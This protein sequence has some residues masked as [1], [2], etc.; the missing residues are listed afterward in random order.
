MADV[1]PACREVGSNKVYAQ[2]RR[3]SASSVIV[4]VEPFV[5]L[6]LALNFLCFGFGACATHIQGASVLRTD[7]TQRKHPFQVFAAAC[8]A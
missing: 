3:N 5:V 1:R 2:R 4:R 6:A 7:G 8:R